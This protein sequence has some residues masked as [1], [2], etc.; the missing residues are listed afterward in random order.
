MIDTYNNLTLEADILKHRINIINTYEEILCLEKDKLNDLLKVQTEIIYLIEKDMCQLTGIENK[1][2]KEIVINGMNVS[3]A[4]D[5][6]SLEEG[7]D[8]STLWKN[9]YP[10]VKKKIEKLSIIKGGIEYERN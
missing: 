10:N 4:I 2:Y 1:L 3:K 6:V 5:K 9:Y 8:V 7:K